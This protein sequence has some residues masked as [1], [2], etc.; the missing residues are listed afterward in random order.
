MTCSPEP[1]VLVGVIVALGGAAVVPAPSSPPRAART[2][3]QPDRAFLHRDAGTAVALGDDLGHDRERGLRRVPAAEVE[4]DRTA[5]PGELLRCHPRVEQPL[6][7]V[8][9]GLARPTAPT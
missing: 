1:V 4:P 6:A 2:D 5:Q 8:G 7:P 9:L 3:A